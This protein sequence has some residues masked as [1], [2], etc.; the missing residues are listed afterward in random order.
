DILPIMGI[1]HDCILSKPGD[2]TAVFKASLPEIFTLSDEEYEQLHQSWLRAIKVLTP[3]TVLH[4]QDW[5]REA[6]H[7]AVPRK[8][9][10][11]FLSRSAARYFEGRPYIL[12]DCYLML[13]KRP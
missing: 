7:S 6:K 12:H 5:F 4:K 13:T 2:V 11:S 9:N 10:D 1:E 3:G 8:D